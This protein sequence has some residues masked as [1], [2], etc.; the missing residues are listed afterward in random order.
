MSR[1]VTVVRL[2]SK[3]QLVI[4]AQ[5]RRKL[6][7]KTGQALAVRTGPDREIVLSPAES[8]SQGVETMLRKTRS[9][10]AGRRRDLVEELH[11]RRR[12]ER[13]RGAGRT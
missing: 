4:P 7:L 2:S 13:E 9:W 3:G 8:E 6:G 12:R 5:L 10:V 11:Q 1:Q